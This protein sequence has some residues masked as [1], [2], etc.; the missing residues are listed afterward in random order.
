VN[1]FLACALELQRWRRRSINSAD[2]P[3]PSLDFKHTPP[4]QL[5]QWAET[6]N[7]AYLEK[8]IVEWVLYW[9]VRWSGVIWYNNVSLGSMTLCWCEYIVALGNYDWRGIM[10]CWCIVCSSS[11]NN[12]EIL[13][14]WCVVSLEGKWEFWANKVRGCS[15]LPSD[16][17]TTL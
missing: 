3:V 16:L 7:A 2:Q 1:L 12:V 8:C 14:V 6:D 15:Q 5:T 10:W 13:L 4:R 9:L 17:V 11:W